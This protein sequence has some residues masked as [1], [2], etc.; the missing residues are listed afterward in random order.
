[1]LAAGSGVTITA[2]LLVTLLNLDR[3]IKIATILG[4]A[5]A[6]VTLAVA[7]AQLIKSS[8][9]SASVRASG[10]GSISAAGDITG[11]ALGQGSEVLGKPSPSGTTK[12]KHAPA[13]IS[14]QGR[15]TI[16]SGGSIDGNALGKHSTVSHKNQGSS[17]DA[18]IT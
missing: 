16:A 14:S 18:P 15:G 4:T 17:P 9:K 13:D 7:I 3:G 10:D 12:S 11:N 1:M 2:L 8:A 5:V 6:V